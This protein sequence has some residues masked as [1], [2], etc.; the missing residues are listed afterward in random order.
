MSTFLTPKEVVSL[1]GRKQKR[2]QKKQLDSL[3]IPY[4]IDAD[5][6]PVVFKSSVEAHQ[7]GNVDV[8]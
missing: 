6:R 3:K 8:S 7:Q 5:G 1:T 4:S 2:P